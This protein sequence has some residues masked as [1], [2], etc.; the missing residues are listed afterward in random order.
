MAKRIMSIVHW[1]MNTEAGIK[2]EL[3]VAIVLI[4]IIALTA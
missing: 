2:A 1:T 3:T 4:L